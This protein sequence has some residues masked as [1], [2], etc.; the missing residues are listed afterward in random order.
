MT[1]LARLAGQLGG[2]RETVA[3]NALG[4]L[5]NDADAAAAFTAA[6]RPGSAGLPGDL[7]YFSQAADGDSRPDVV[8]RNERREVV[9]VEGKFWAGLTEAQAG[10]RY[11]ER[12]NRQY[13]AVAAD[14]PCP[15][16][17]LWV[18]PRRR[19]E[20]L[21]PEVCRIST[22]QPRQAGGRWRFADTPTGQVVALTEWSAISD[23]LEHAGGRELAED[24][25]QFRALIAE[26]DRHGFVPWSVGDLTDQQFARQWVAVRNVATT[27]RARAQKAGVATRANPSRNS[28]ASGPMWEG[29]AM[30]LAN[31]YTALIV[32]LPLFAEHGTTPLWLRWWHGPAEVARRAFPGRTVERDRGCALPLPFPP[33][34]LEGEVVDDAVAFLRECAV[35]L[36]A[37]VRPTDS[38]DFLEEG[39]AADELEADGPQ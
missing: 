8:G 34:R 39:P 14:D 24:V 23:V 28:N 3:T 11:V 18:C 7:R 30:R 26:V 25:R 36:E 35:R 20:L 1:L 21:W 16:I 4:H 27:I 29:P 31:V 38:L 9:H 6:L 37:A 13:E 33:G 32:S 10:N 19:V 22:A 15:G 5:L 12:L 17:L 2:L